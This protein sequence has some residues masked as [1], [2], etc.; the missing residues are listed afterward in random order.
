MYPLTA[1]YGI[2]RRYP[3]LLSIPDRIYVNKFVGGALRTSRH[4]KNLR[5]IY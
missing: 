4:Y 1:A 2:V 5:L 3:P